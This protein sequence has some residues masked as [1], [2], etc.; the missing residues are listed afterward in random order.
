MIFLG[1]TFCGGSGTGDLTPTKVASVD[2][3]TIKNGI[4]D[5]LYIT[6]KDV[7]VT[8][9][10]S[11]IWDFD[12]IISAAFNGNLH[13][14]NIEYTVSQ[15]SAIRIKRRVKNTFDWVSLFE[16]PITSV[17]DLN[18]ERIDRFAKSGIEYEYALVPMIGNIEGTFNTNT[19]LSE[20]DG[21][22][23]STIDQTVSTVLDTEVTH[24]RTRPSS[25]VTT[26]GSRFPFVLINGM[27]NYYSGTAKGTFIGIDPETKLYNT[28]YQNGY[29]KDIVDF[30][31]DGR[32]KFLKYQDGRAWIIAVVDK[33]TDTANGHEENI[34]TAFQWVEIGDA[35]SG[36]DLYNNGL[37]AVG[38][39]GR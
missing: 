30:I 35:E 16:I 19:V 21:I 10:L 36:V 14:G 27:S 1:K 15:I 11:K 32:P 26:L 22:I 37:I 13:C 39:E 8:S 28:K 24:S 31:Y 17:N 18:F 38:I 29:R 3:M 23:I 20:F 9:P 12:T 4:F 33:I 6:K 7:D 2:N 34:S 25:M 5:D